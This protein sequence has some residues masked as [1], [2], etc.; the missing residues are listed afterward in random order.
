MKKKK[1]MIIPIIFLLIFIIAIFSGCLY[2]DQFPIATGP[3]SVNYQYINVGLSGY[4]GVLLCKARDHRFVYDNDSHENWEDYA[5]VK[6]ADNVPPDEFR[7]GAHLGFFELKY[8]TTYYVRAVA[9]LYDFKYPYQDY[10]EGF[11]QGEQKTF[12]IDL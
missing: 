12:Y 7:Y 5:Y 4:V 9:Y 11:Y 1:K 8:K 2:T 10:E 6:Y 3:P